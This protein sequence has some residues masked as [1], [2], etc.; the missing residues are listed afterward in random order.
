MVYCTCAP[1]PPRV[2]QRPKVT[3][4]CS[5]Q[6]F[7]D[8]ANM[9]AAQ[10][11]RHPQANACLTATDTAEACHYCHE[12]SSS[13]SRLIGNT[14][15]TIEMKPS[16]FLDPILANVPSARIRSPPQYYVDNLYRFLTP[17]LLTCGSHW[18]SN[19]SLPC[20]TMIARG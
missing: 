16:T 7:I 17:L 12:S 13:S 15:M 20:R 2:P 6:L 10:V 1:L 4:S 9:Q 8:S 11:Q 14:K 18:L 19:P 3:M 5:I